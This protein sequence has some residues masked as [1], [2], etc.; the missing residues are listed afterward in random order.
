[1][2]KAEGVGGSVWGK[3]LKIHKKLLG[4]PA[5]TGHFSN[6]FITNVIL[7]QSQLLK[8]ANV[9]KSKNIMVK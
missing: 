9:Y 6:K 2:G 7:Y 5:S 3:W 4:M 1:M 8:K